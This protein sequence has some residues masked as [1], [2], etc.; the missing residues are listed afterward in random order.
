M[1]S[2]QDLPSLE[3]L[4]KNI[5]SYRYYSGVGT[6]NQN[7][8]PYGTDTPGGGNSGQPFIVRKVDQRWSPS[9]ID[10]GFTQFGTANLVSRT[11]ADVLRVTKF[12]YSTP[13]GP[14]FL[15][16]Q[17][18]LQR[19]N[20]NIDQV[21]PTKKETKVSNTQTYG[22]AG[23]TTLAEVGVVGAGIHFDRHGIFPKTG[24]SNRYENYILQKDREGEN[25]LS[26]LS[27]KLAKDY[28]PD[29]IKYSGGPQS[30]FGIGSTTIKR[31]YN[32]ISSAYLRD[33]S[34]SEIKI[35][36]GFIYFPHNELF[37]ISGDSITG[38]KYDSFNNPGT[39]DLVS[40]NGE[41]F[42]ANVPSAT[43]QYDL[44]KV[45]FRQVKNSLRSNL[46]SKPNLSKPN[47]E[48]DKY[49]TLASSDYTK[50]NLETRVGIPR[51]RKPQDK[52]SYNSEPN[53]YTSHD[54][55]NAISLYYSNVSHNEDGKLKD[56]NDVPVT[57]AEIRD[58]VKF[59]I[60]VL[61]N[62]KPLKADSTHY[63]VYIIFRAYIANIRRNVTS[64]WDP[65]KY[66]GR[67]ESFY[68]YDGFTETI[69]ISFTIAASSRKE[70]KP[71][72]QKLNYLIASMAPDYSS[73]GAM[74]GSISE[75]T[76]GDL[77]LYQ[78]GIITNLD[79]VIDE[80]SNWE[81]ALQEP[82]ST[83]DTGTDNDMHELPQLIKCTMTFIP[84]YNFL[85]RKSASSKFFGVDGLNESK[86]Q[87]QW[88]K[89]IQDKLK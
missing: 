57:A 42:Q 37:K 46:L 8:L 81:I 33:S 73:A 86:V 53:G 22:P 29:L 19:M 20:P 80:D 11:V 68:I 48:T 23:L 4:S 12:L 2:L 16:K 75:I 26:G 34:M 32:S 7:N 52:I 39:I 83:N 58:I 60:K 59:R 10:D 67:G 70:M 69:T 45:D 56:V 14:L 21:D 49:Y 65:Y 36:Q 47:N 74:R 31:K 89:G 44:R 40:Q 24:D 35:N 87:K 84:L 66:V 63:G 43:T 77:F 41:V 15:F 13:K 64:K 54:R 25:R 38:F 88:L 27:S 9:N 76:I 79:M 3:E 5:F 72:Y 18:G 6:F 78:P 62:D 1:P 71:L 55:I 30:F 85:P 50:Y 61:D 82:E 51:A 17:T 28:V